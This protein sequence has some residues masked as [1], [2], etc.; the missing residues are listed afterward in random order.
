MSATGSGYPVR[1]TFVPDEGQ[2][3]LWGIPLLGVM[4]RSILVIPHALILAV[5]TLVAFFV[6][7]VAWAPILFQGRMAGWGYSVFGGILRLSLW[8]TAYV[9]LMTGRYPPFGL[10]G[11]HP[12][13]L[14]FDEAEDQNRLWGIPVL[15]VCVRAILVIPHAIVLALLGIAVGLMALFT[16]IPVLL[17]GR[18]A[19]WVIR[20]IGGYYRWS[21]RVSAYLLLLTGR[22]PP[23]SL[24]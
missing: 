17:D 3:R 7:L 20:Y 15:G 22:Y 14:D 5:M 18:T 8:L 6:G 10:T 23:F 19:D 24:D 16:W 9:T 2:S 13:R 12:V 11:D 21:T 1:V 4:L